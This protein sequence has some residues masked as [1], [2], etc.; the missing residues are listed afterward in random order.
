MSI[1]YDS[2]V[3]DLPTL[4]SR[5][6]ISF[7]DKKEAENHAWLLNAFKDGVIAKYIVVP[8]VIEFYMPVK[9]ISN[10]KTIKTT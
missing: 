9:E 1:N 7:I 5:M 2:V 4:S 10:D 8:S 6:V 3:E